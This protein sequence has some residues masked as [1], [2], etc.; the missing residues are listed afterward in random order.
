VTLLAL[1]DR[2]RSL[3]DGERRA[4]LGIAG[5]PGAGKSTLVAALL[6]ALGD[7]PSP[8]EDGGG[9]W[10]THVPM[11]G[12]HIA[13]VQLDRL[14]LRDRKGAPETFDTGG[15]LSLL[16]RIRQVPLSLVYA[17]GFERRL[18]QPI[19]ASIAVPSSAR[20]VITEGNYLLM[21]TGDWPLVRAE[22]DE[23]WYL[24]VDDTQ[25]VRRLVDRHVEFGKSPTA[26]AEWVHRSD[27]ANALLVSSS[28][29]TADLV[30]R[31][32]DLALA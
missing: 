17:P 1:A 25:R 14:G 19:A 29:D 21:Q 18:E 22:L 12:F 13:D 2:A 30:L 8:V 6:D 23:V 10:V 26:A 32:A 15:Y 27:E 7:R 9:P 20:L 28:R 31:P 16:Q 4:V 11:D 3:L 5:P 24:D